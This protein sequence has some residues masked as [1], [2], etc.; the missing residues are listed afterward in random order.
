MVLGEPQILGQ[1]KDAYD[2]AVAAGALKGTSA[3]A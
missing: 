2:A 3:A 1:V